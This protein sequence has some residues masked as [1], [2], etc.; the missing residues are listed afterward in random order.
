M[1]W[2]AGGDSR[3]PVS[4]GL[5]H[6]VD[7]VRLRGTPRDE[8]TATIPGIAS[9]LGPNHV[10]VVLARGIRLDGPGKG[11]RR[12][13][14][15]IGVEIVGEAEVGVPLIVQ[16]KADERRRGIVTDARVERLLGRPGRAFVIGIGNPER[17]VGLS[18][19]DVATGGVLRDI[20][21]DPGHID[22]PGVQLSR[23]DD[24]DAGRH[25]VAEGVALRHQRAADRSRGDRRAG[26]NL[27]GRA[28]RLAAIE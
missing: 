25:G 16:R 28:E 27:L 8:A 7:P 24:L 18:H 20:G 21:R 14:R 5:L 4:P 6:R 26:Q 1:A 19:G 15:G 22:A 9:V 17:V 2:I 12:A 23:L 13:G 11:L 3:E 10:H